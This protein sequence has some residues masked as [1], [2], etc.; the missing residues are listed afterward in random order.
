[1]TPE[2]AILKQ[3]EIYSAGWWHGWETTCDDIYTQ[4]GID[5]TVDEA[6]KHMKNL[7]KMGFVESKPIFTH[8]M[9]LNGKG[10]FLTKEGEAFIK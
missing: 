10:W 2:Q 8:E 9:K 3:L 4:H 7:Q 5:L 1:M 6:K